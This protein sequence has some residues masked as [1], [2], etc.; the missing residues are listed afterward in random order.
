MN[1]SPT[2][3]ASTV[4][5]ERVRPERR[6]RVLRFAAQGQQIL[7]QSASSSFGGVG[8]TLQAWFQKPIAHS[9]VS[10]YGQLNGTGLIGFTRQHF[11]ETIA[12]DGQT[13]TQS[14]APR[15]REQ[16]RGHLRRG[17]RT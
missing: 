5:G 13:L 11:S 9:P 17:G 10:L 8:P 7:E 15:Q 16:R 14:V 1:L 2:P 12:D 3:H 6:R 4:P